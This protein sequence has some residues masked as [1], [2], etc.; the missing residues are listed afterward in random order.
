M[1]ED[2]M[3]MITGVVLVLLAALVAFYAYS[4]WKVHEKNTQTQTLIQLCHGKIK[5]RARFESK[6]NFTKTDILEQGSKVSIL[7]VVDL[8]NGLGAMIPHKYLCE[9]DA[10]TTQFKSEPILMV[11][12]WTPKDA[13]RDILLERQR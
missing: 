10:T 2:G 8:M 1:K 12:G 9:I 6:V 3:S 7:G 13:L 4:E 5:A 11:E